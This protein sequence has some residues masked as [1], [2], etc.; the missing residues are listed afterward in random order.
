MH[1]LPITSVILAT[2]FLSSAIPT[3]TADLTPRACVTQYPSLFDH[4]YEASPNYANSQND[5][6]EIAYDTVSGQIGRY[7]R[8]VVV[9]FDNIPEGSYGCQLEAYF[10]AGGKVDQYGASQ[11]NVFTV[12]KQ[13][14]LGDTWNT[15]PRQRSLFGTITFEVNP[16]EPVKRVINS[17]VCNSTLTYRFTIAS[18]TA[19]GEVYFQEGSSFNG[20]VLRLTH[21]C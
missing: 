5:F 21:N 6:F 4:I 1:V 3:G 18:T 8:D 9:Q 14:T 11:V 2:A 19:F 15:A 20:Q 13:A 10:P 12:D 7:R 16:N 17:G